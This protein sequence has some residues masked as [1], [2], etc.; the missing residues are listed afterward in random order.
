MISI[1]TFTFIEYKEHL[2]L[3]KA[4]MD[5]R[6]IA[7]NI[8]LKRWFNK[9]VDGQILGDTL[10]F[11]HK[12]ELTGMTVAIWSSSNKW[13]T[14]YYYYWNAL[15]HLLNTKNYSYYKKKKLHTFQ[16]TIRN[17]NIIDY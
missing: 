16:L 5:T 7:L 14:E 2:K 3:K 11:D 9:L 6:K 12:T 17:Y 4:G 15:L 13:K 1:R 8:S 10:I